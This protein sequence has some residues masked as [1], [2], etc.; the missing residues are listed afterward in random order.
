VIEQRQLF[1]PAKEMV[2]AAIQ[3]RRRDLWR[4]LVTRPIECRRL[5]LRPGPSLGLAD[6]R[7]FDAR[8]IEQ[9]IVERVVALFRRQ[10]V[11]GVASQRLWNER[12]VL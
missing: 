10:G 9:E 3:P 8:L 11:V 6:R 5:A 2:G 1:V 12:L 7:R 4:R